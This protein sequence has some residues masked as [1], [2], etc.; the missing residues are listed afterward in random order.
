MSEADIK[1]KVMLH[2][3]QKRGAVVF[4]NPVGNGWVGK[5]QSHNQNGGVVKLLGARRVSFGL[6]GGSADLIGWYPLTIKPEHVG[7]KIAVFFAGETKTQDNKPTP[8]QSNFLKRV[9]DDGGIAG[10]IRSNE[11]ADNLIDKWGKDV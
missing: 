4:T 1:S 2:L 3:S 7:K 8:A 5:F 10:I 6:I 9:K 11:D